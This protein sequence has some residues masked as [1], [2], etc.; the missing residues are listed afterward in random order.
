MFFVLKEKKKEPCKTHDSCR[1][2]ELHPT[3]KLLYH[4]GG[5]RRI[6]YEKAAS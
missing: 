6:L 1:P 4:D 5:V 3:K 2:R